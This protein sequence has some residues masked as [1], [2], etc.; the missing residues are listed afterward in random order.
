MDGKALAGGTFGRRGSVLRFE[1]NLVIDRASQP[2]LTSEV[3]LRRFH[4]NMPEK[5]LDLLKFSAR[6]MA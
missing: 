4:R 5:E 6:R 1:A 2:L 3:S